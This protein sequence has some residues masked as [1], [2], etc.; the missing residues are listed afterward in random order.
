MV[1]YSENIAIFD[2]YLHICKI[3]KYV[4]VCVPYTV[5]GVGG[6]HYFFKDVIVFFTF[7]HFKS[8]KRTLAHHP[9]SRTLEAPLYRIY[10]LGRIC[11]EVTNEYLIFLATSKLHLVNDNNNIEL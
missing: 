4:F 5:A 8:Q 3:L 11:K 7:Y 10:S 2:D 9:I 6:T 1:L